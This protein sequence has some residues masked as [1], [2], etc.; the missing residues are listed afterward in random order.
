MLTTP[1]SAASAATDRRTALRDRHRRALLDAAAEL[2]AE[3]GGAGFT[4]D[5]LAA[6]A[7]VA[8]R[9]VFN[10]FASL[11]D[12]VTTVCTELLSGVVDRILAS[13]AASGRASSSSIFDELVHA[14]R[15][16]D[17]VGPMAFVTHALGDPEAHPGRAALLLRTMHDLS[18]RVAGALAQ[19]HPDADPLE[20]RILVNSL[21]SGLTV[22]HEPWYAATG[23]ADDDRSRR[24]WDELLDRL[25]DNVRAG[26]RTDPD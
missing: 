7:D 15:T 8:R 18:A 9:T 23:G 17:V 12:V 5:E 25:V 21:V 22:L 19:R 4:V 11:D 16:T 14:L 3:A 24:V 26:Y 13:T 10:H 2:M 20:V 1:A 6:R